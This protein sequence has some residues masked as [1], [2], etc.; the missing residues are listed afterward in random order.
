[1]LRA[2]DVTAQLL[3]NGK[4]VPAAILNQSIEFTKNFM[5]VCHH[6]K[7]EETLFPALER[8]GDAARRGPNSADDL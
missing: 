6:G 4:P 1:M 5:L 7:E 2:L 8:Q 3:Q